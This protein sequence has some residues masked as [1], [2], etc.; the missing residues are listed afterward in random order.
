ML[1]IVSGILKGDDVWRT[2]TFYIALVPLILSDWHDIQGSDNLETDL[3]TSTRLHL[4]TNLTN[5]KHVLTL[6][7]KDWKIVFIDRINFDTW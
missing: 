4:L 6:F 5:A 2:C 1:I 3:E 7:H